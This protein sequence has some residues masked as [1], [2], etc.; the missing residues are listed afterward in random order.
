MITRVLFI[1][2]AGNGAYDEDRLLATSLQKELG[3]NYEVDYLKMPDE[4]NAPYELWKETIEKEIDADQAPLILVG[5]SMGASYIVKI[6]TEIKQ[7]TSLIGIFLL[8]TPFWGGDGWLYEGY[9]EVEFPKDAAAKLP[10]DM[11]VFYHTHDDEVV[12]FS[13]LDLYAKVFP[14]AKR[15]EIN[16]GG[17]QLGNDLSKI[18]TDIKRL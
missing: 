2:G 4:E 16:A 3:S 15:R 1:H 17:H 10:Q 14:H 8:E 18:A 5:H 6:L 13:H 12:P 9:E 11:M 7:N